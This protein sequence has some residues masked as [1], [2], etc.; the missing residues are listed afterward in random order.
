[1]VKVEPNVWDE[2]ELNF[3]NPNHMLGFKI[4]IYLFIYFYLGC[5]KKGNHFTFNF[6]FLF[7][8]SKWFLVAGTAHWLNPFN[9]CGLPWWIKGPGWEEIGWKVYYFLWDCWWRM[10]LV[11]VIRWLKHVYFR[12]ALMHGGK[13]GGIIINIGLVR[14]KRAAG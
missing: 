13:K 5:L 6:F 1:M 11:S 3:Y 12:E 7:N 10:L 14:G 4:K 2:T 9:K 8:P